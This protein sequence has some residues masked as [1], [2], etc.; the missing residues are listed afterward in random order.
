MH[1]AAKLVKTQELMRCLLTG[2]TLR[3]CATQLRI[4]YFTVKK[5]AKEPDFLQ[6]LKS[7]SSSVY[8]RLDRE[9]SVQKEQI[10][11]RLEQA[12]ADALERLVEIMNDPQAN[13]M[14]QFKAAQD[15]CD[16]DPRISRTK[17]VESQQDVRFINP[18]VLLHAAATAREVEEYRERQKELGDG[19][20]SA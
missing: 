20:A 19:N 8:E 4:S 10:L 7:L 3:E 11:E 1:D 9:L 14:V 12:S 6:E 2:L 15:L 18:A 17:R 16:R 13:K 5:Y